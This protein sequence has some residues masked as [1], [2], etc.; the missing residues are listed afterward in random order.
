MVS[1][2]EHWEQT[3]KMETID[4]ADTSD[5]NQIDL[6]KVEQLFEG[7]ISPVCTV[8]DNSISVMSCDSPYYGTFYDRDKQPDQKTQIR[9]D[10]MWAGMCADQSHPEKS[11]VGCGGCPRHQLHQQQKQQTQQQQQ[12][13]QHQQQQ[14][15]SIIDTAGNLMPSKNLLKVAKI[16]EQ[17]QQTGK[18][19]E[20]AKSVVA[21]CTA[22][23]ASH[24]NTT[25][26]LPVAMKSM[27]NSLRT[28]FKEAQTSAQIPAGSS[29]LIRRQQ[30]LSSAMF[31]Q[32]YKQL[33]P[34]PPSSSESCTSLSEGGGAG[35]SEP[36]DT[37]V[38][39][40]VP[41]LPRASFL[42]VREQEARSIAAQNHARPDT[43]LSLD[44]DPLE[45]KHNL[46]LVA[47]CTIGSNQQSLLRTASSS[48]SPIANSSSSSSG[49]GSASINVA[50]T[51]S[52]N[53]F[54]TATS[55]G[56]AESRTGGLFG[57]LGGNCTCGAGS[58]TNT[59]SIGSGSC[60]TTQCYYNYLVDTSST[61]DMRKKQLDDPYG[62][63][64]YL[65]NQ[66]AIPRPDSPYSLLEQVLSDLREIDDNSQTHSYLL[67]DQQSSP[68]TSSG[69]LAK[70]GVQFSL[71]PQQQQQQHSQRNHH[72]SSLAPC[73]GGLSGGAHAACNK[74]CCWSSLELSHH[75]ASPGN[76]R[77][78]RHQFAHRRR[79][80]T[81]RGWISDD[82]EDEEDDVLK[83]LEEDDEELEKHFEQITAGINP[84]FPNTSIWEDDDEEEEDDEEEDEEESEE[85]EDEDEE[86]DDRE[87]DEE[88]DE[89][90]E[91][92][93]AQNGSMYGGDSS[94]SRSR[95]RNR[96]SR[97]H[98]YRNQYN[99]Q[100]R[101][102][103]ARAS[104]R[105]YDGEQ[106]GNGKCQKL[107]TT[108]LLANGTVSTIIAG[109]GASL[110]SSI[111]GTKGSTSCNGSNG[112]MSNTSATSTAGHAQQSAGATGNSY[113]ATHFGDHSYTRPKGGYNMNEL[114]VQ[115]PSDSDEEI[116][117]VSVGDKNLPTN[118]T[119]R[120]YRHLQSEVASK[121]RTAS[122]RGTTNGSLPYGSSAHHHHYQRQ[123]QLGDG[124]RQGLNHLGGIYPTP[125]SS[126]TISGA[127][128]P[129]PTRSGGASAAS[130]PPPACTTGTSGSASRKRPVGGG[131][132]SSKRSSNSSKRMRPA[133][134]KRGDGNGGRYDS[135]ALTEELDTVEKRNLHNNLERQRRIGLKNL[136]EELKRQIPQLRDK[137]RAPK[138]NIL[139]E[140]AT[141]CNRL[142]QE[143]EQ[144][145]E[146][147]QQQIKLYERV[148]YLRA[149]MHSHRHGVE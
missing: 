45:F 1:H 69:V 43:P 145:N 72:Q 105:P 133:H 86:K 52:S 137:D 59:S 127:N 3:I 100:H 116:D 119:E 5:F 141:L 138:V 68:A 36:G 149:T 113:Q 71:H 61:E 30:Q 50:P 73:G 126:T 120:D 7:G 60:H 108:N 29:L 87:V 15:S 38:R 28:P 24:T 49:N 70:D 21:N 33:P 107:Q 35:G 148:R 44:D 112:S 96:T 17:Q 57:R 27:I 23:P 140:A 84:I 89:E 131:S 98:R 135:C 4:D 99:H 6:S 124:P 129:L 64:E 91:E 85:E 122:S 142:N 48:P 40:R 104:Y 13:L 109:S 143:A 136:F 26:T 95:S 111:L 82:D 92:E 97:H 65:Y 16:S 134:S 12:Q 22:L 144:V 54:S 25:T 41:N 77:K 56:G 66:S 78:R 2:Q 121:I 74:E 51:T 103:V 102:S 101:R 81:A 147:R 42:R 76:E 11:S 19:D 39:V 94:S 37:S 117:V 55:S 18:I 79:S 58:I 110:K 67:D 118:P 14:F 139:R 80:F 46:D 114:G 128:T 10:C 62:L 88:E 146:L 123:H 63:S 93:D 9:H 8:P 34:S 130:S 20:K 83:H 125:A 31:I 53:N 106:Y 75:L 132:S 115:T 90:E 32:N 47:T